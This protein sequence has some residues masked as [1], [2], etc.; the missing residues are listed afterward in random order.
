MDCQRL[1]RVGLGAANILLSVWKLSGAYTQVIRT[2]QKSLEVVYMTCT[3][4]N[5]QIWGCVSKSCQFEDFLS[6]L[7]DQNVIHAIKNC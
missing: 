6:I 7:I 2:T 3:P 4:C 5:Y 1:F